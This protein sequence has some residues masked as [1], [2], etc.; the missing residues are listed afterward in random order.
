M[1]GFG[2]FILLSEREGVLKARDG[3][4]MKGCWVS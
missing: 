3:E 2:G 1:I 4:Q